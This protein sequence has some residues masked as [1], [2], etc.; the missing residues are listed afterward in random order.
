MV[1][2]PEEESS[3]WEFSQWVSGSFPNFSD[4]EAEF[5]GSYSAFGHSGTFKIGLKLTDQNAGSTS[6]PCQVTLNGKTD[7][8][9]SYKVAAQK[10]TIKTSLVNTTDAPVH[11]TV[12][13]KLEAIS[14]SQDVDLAAKETKTVTF[15][16]TSTP[17][18]NLQAPR[19]WW[20]AQLGKQELYQVA[21]SASV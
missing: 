7:K 12:S 17:A 13:G 3:I 19:L 21:L 9:A 15:D 11:T 16:A 10:L 6:G 1:R 14:F 4:F 20:P 8:T 5:D 18:L 2:I